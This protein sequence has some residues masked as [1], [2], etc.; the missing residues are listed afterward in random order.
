MHLPAFTGYEASMSYAPVTGLMASAPH[1]VWV[2][3]QLAYY[4]EHRHF[5]LQ[6]GSLDMTPNTVT[7]A[8]IMQEGGFMIDGQYRV[9]KD[10]LHVFPVDYFCPLT[11]TRVLKLTKNT[12]CIHHFAGSWVERT[13]WQK[14]KQ[15]ITQKVLGTKLTD[16][17]VNVKRRLVKGKHKI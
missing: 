8:R 16:K 9:Y 12:Y 2:S 6:D 4:D 7:I 10:D 13:M 1:G 17:L 11:S 14:M 3:E 5:R 15:L